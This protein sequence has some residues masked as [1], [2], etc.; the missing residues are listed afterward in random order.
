MGVVGEL[1]PEITARHDLP[2]RVA[3]LLVDLGRLLGA[4]ARGW[5]ARTVSRFPA[6]DLDVAFVVG[7]EVPAGALGVTVREAAG[8]LAESVALFDVWRD[9]SLGEGKRSLAFRARLRAS[10][11]TLTEQEV[12]GVRDRVASAALDRHGAVLRGA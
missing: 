11:R 8:D 7:E 6:S 5:A 1:S 9:P 10:N 3:V 2:G 4:P 12:A